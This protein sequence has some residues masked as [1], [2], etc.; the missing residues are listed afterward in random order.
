MQ[1]KSQEKFPDSEIE[2]AADTSPEAGRG[3]MGAVEQLPREV[4][5]GELSAPTGQGPSAAA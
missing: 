4:Q 1:T 3:W 2:W 5:G